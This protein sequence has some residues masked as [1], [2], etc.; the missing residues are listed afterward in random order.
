M[1]ASPSARLPQVPPGA[2]AQPLHSLAMY[3]TPAQSCC[4]GAHR[5]PSQP[6]P[7]F[8]SPCQ[9]AHCSCEMQAWPSVLLGP[10]VPP[11]APSQPLHSLGQYQTFAK[12]LTV[13]AQVLPQHAVPPFSV[14]AE[15]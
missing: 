5:P 12:S 7:S 3:H 14:K 1:Q 4:I 2:P 10:Q 6:E 8:P 11:G 15:V 13:F 9:L